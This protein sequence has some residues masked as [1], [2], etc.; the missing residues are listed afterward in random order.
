MQSALQPIQ[1]GETVVVVVQVQ[2]D[3]VQV[4]VDNQVTVAV[5][6]EVGGNKL[7]WRRFADGNLQGVVR[8]NRECQRRLRF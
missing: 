6:V 3:V 4:P 5:Q 8:Q 2:C 1:A 7:E